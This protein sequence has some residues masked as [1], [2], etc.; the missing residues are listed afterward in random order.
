M[1]LRYLP[2]TAAADLVINAVDA[3][4]QNKTVTADF[5]HMM[6]DATWLSCSQ[7]TDAVVANM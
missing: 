7:F 6:E 3:A 5:A 2:W 1:L 4:I